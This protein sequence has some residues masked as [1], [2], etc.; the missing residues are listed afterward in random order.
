MFNI[1]CVIFAGGKSSRMGED[2]TLLP[3]GNSPSLTH[4][5]YHRLKELFSKVF[6]SCKDKSKFD[7][8]ADFI[9]EDAKGFAPTYGFIAAF[10][11]CS[12]DTFFALSVDTPL[13]TQNEIAKILIADTQSIDATIAKVDGKIQPLCGVYHKTLYKDFLQMAQSNTHKL[14]FLLK[15]KKTLYVDFD[16]PTPF[17]NCN[18]PHQYQEAQ[19]LFD[20]NN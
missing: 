14:G 7:F 4:F 5:Q 11:Q 20:T 10:E 12:C 16:D 2:K 9:E 6:I 13:I 15:N 3:F 19:K 18:Y 17:F 8:G 1:P